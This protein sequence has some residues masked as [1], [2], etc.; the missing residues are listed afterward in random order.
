MVFLL[1]EELSP[2][3]SKVRF[4]TAEEEL[5]SIQMQNGLCS[6]HYFSNIMRNH[7]NRHPLL[8]I[9][10]FQHGV[11]FLLC[12]RIQSG[13]RFIHNKELLTC[14]E[15]SR[16]ENPLSLPAGQFTETGIL[17]IFYF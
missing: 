17:Q 4:R 8:S 13:N 2:A 12:Q 11:Q 16:K 1:Y 6:F 14:S 9:Q 5:L 3:G 7:D 10:T 15:G